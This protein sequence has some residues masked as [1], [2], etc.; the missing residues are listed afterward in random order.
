[1]IKGLDSA[2]VFC[3]SASILPPLKTRQTTVEALGSPGF[4]WVESAVLAD[5]ITTNRSLHTRD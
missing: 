2:L 4:T 3:G 1:M 5:G